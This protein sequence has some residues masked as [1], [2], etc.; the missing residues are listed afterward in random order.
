MRA[1]E[2]LLLN[3]G[4]G[5]FYCMWAGSSGGIQR[6]ITEWGIS[7]EEKGSKGGYRGKKGETASKIQEGDHGVAAGVGKFK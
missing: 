1:R 3:V 4:R 2:D 7:S 5:W 6:D